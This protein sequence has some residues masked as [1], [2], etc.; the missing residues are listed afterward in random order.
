MITTVIWIKLGRDFP[1][2]LPIAFNPPPAASCRH[3]SDAA[4][5]TSER[6]YRLR[7]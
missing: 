2:P 4:K 6:Q 1:I 5:A 3:V 7:D